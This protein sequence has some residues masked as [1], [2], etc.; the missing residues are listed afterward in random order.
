[1]GKDP[2]VEFRGGYVCLK[3]LVFPDCFV[4]A[5]GVRHVSKHDLACWES[6][7]ADFQFQKLKDS[8]LGYLN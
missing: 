8:N 7:F 4:H 6:L 3:F 2:R 5:A 1:M